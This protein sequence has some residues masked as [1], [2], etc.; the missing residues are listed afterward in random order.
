M[1][2]RV[3]L[4][5]LLAVVACG[6]PVRTRYFTL[7]SLV[8]SE[9]FPAARRASGSLGVGPVT[10]P[11][12][13]RRAQL[14]TRVGPSEV[15]LSDGARWSEPLADG[16][17]RALAANLQTLLGAERVQL[18]PWDP[19]FPPDQAV[20]VELFRFE[21]QPGSEVELLA[22]WWVRRRTSEGLVLHETR[23]REPV[24]TDD[25]S[26]AVDALGRTLAGLSREIAEALRAP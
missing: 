25:P 16:V 26:A 5:V 3:P 11:D 24:G 4:A 22:R 23:L 14:V 6:A 10:L 19:R 12:Y 9:P 21:K 13:L 2:R 7:T 8:D 17:A 20:A 15:H 1:R 18:F